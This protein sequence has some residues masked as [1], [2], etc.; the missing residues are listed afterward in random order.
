MKTIYNTLLAACALLLL[1]SCHSHKEE[2]TEKHQAEMNEVLLTPE[3]FKTVNI[4]YDRVKERVLGLTIKA[5]GMLDVPPQN[6]VNISSPFGGFIKKT[7]LL[8]GMK[9]K[10]GQALAVLE[11]SDFVQFQQDYLDYK[12]QLDYLKLEYERQKQLAEENVNSKKVLQKAKSEYESM[13][14]KVMGLEAKLEMMNINVNNL[15]QGKISPLI[16]LYSPINGYITEVNTN[17]GA[18]V[19][20]TDVLFKIIDTEHLHAELTVFEKDVP[21]IK[22]GQKVKF[23]LVNEEKEREAEVYLIGREISSDRTVRVHC[24]LQTEDT[25]LLPGTFISAI[26]ETDTN[27]LPSL[28]DEAITSINGKNYVF[29]KNVSDSDEYHFEVIEVEKGESESGYTAVV[30][31]ENFNWKSAEIVVS[32]AYDLLS[33]LHNTEEEGGGHGH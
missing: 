11:H 21:K 3:Q 19:N 8:Q 24:H 30:F 13:N 32:G 17:I 4:Q 26:I 9:V 31:P 5:T 33:K 10:K 12:S 16:T 27:R 22:I 25:E 1:Y 7:E 28:P 2:T 23:H 14:A 15:E 29:A 20:P 18:F 6:L